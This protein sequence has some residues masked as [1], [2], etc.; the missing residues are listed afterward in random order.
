MAVLS[1]NIDIYT[2]KYDNIFLGDF[3]A[4]LED[5]SIKNFCVAYSLTSM[6]NKPTCYKNPG[7][8][9]SFN[10]IL[11]NCPRFFLK[12]SCVLELGLSDFHKMFTTVMKTTLRKMEPK[13]IKCCDYKYFCNDTFRE[14]LQNIF[15]QNLKINCDDY[16]T[17]FAIS[18]KNVLDKI[19][20]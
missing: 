14:S 18:C 1:K 19:A 16:Y 15:S 2:T 17:N 7:K 8:P 3:Y 5:A 11:T 13:V 4:R 6:I 9:S 12:N 10:L 20:P